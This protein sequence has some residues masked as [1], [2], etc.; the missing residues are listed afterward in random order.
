[1]LASLYQ[2]S[3]FEAGIRIFREDEGGR[4]SAPFNGIKWDFNYASEISNV[5]LYMIW[6]DFIDANRH[7]LP[8]DKALPVDAYLCARMFIVVDEM[9]AQMH[10]SRIKIG[11][12]FYCCEGPRRVAEGEVNMITGLHLERVTSTSELSDLTKSQVVEMIRAN[13]SVEAVRAIRLATGV[14]LVEAKTQLESIIG[15]MLRNSGQV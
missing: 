3:D 5:G 14:G 15:E 11:T 2:F 12:R 6:P 1:M 10:R 9:R 8:T 7:S 4:K 13:R